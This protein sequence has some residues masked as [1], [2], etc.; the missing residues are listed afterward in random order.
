VKNSEINI[1]IKGVRDILETTEL[2]S[3]QMSE[4]S[5]TNRRNC[6]GKLGCWGMEAEV[7]NNSVQEVASQPA[8]TQLFLVKEVLSI[9]TAVILIHINQINSSS[10]RNNF[11]YNLRFSLLMLQINWFISFKLCLWLIS[12]VCYLKTKTF[13]IHFKKTPN[14]RK[15]RIQYSY[16]CWRKYRLSTTS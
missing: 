12:S 5:I 9:H 8:W 1:L 4:A 3:L 13:W 2:A 7:A 6:D 14:L 11:N 10:L 15:N 16:V